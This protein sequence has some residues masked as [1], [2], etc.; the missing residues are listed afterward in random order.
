METSEVGLNAFFIMIRVQTCRSQGVECGVLKGNGTIGSCLNTWCSG[1]GTVWGGLK[2]DIFVGAMSLGVGFEVSKAHARPSFS[3]YNL[4]TGCKLS[5]TSPVPCLS[6]ATLGVMV[7]V[8]SPI[9][10]FKC[11]LL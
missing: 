11:L 4:K 5:A 9:E 3:L 10:T 1:H 8:D 2:G 6:V 7:I